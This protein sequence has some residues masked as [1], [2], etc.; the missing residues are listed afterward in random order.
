MEEERGKEQ[1]GSQSEY[2]AVTA[3]Q[4]KSCCPYNGVYVR[5]KESYRNT[6]FLKIWIIK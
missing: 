2:L 5:N 1:R 3:S 4:F 6:F